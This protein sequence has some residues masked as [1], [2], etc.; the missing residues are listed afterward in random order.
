MTEESKKLEHFTSTILEDAQNQRREIELAAQEV[1]DSRV[2]TAE[3]EIIQKA[4]RYQEIEIAKI[5]SNSGK[6][7]SRRL[8]DGKRSLFMK[9]GEIAIKISS[10]LRSRLCAWTGGDKYPQWL[11]S[12]IERCIKKLD[13]GNRHIVVRCRET[14]LDIVSSIMERLRPDNY[15][16]EIT[17]FKIGGVCVLCPDENILADDTLDCAFEDTKDHIAEYIGLRLE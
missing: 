16:T 9:R 17:P 12:S 14:D 2:N 11:A 7:T 1:F 13:C 15:A 3:Q 8:L 10:D 6:E 5:K 4:A